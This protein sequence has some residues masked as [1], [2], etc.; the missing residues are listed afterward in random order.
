[1]RQSCS[2]ESPICLKKSNHETELFIESKI[3]QKKSNH[4][5]ELYYRKQDV[6]EEEQS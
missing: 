2:I 3:C 5:T 6:S 4:E 1:M